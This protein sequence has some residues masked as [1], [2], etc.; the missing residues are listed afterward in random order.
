[1]S[2][3][4][5][6]LPGQSAP[7]LTGSLVGLASSLLSSGSGGSLEQERKKV[8]NMKDL[9]V[10]ET[11]RSLIGVEMKLQEGEK[12]EW[13]Y[14]MDVPLA[15]PP[16]HR[17]RAWTIEY[18][19]VLSVGV[20]LGKEERVEEVVSPVR[21]WSGVSCECTLAVKVSLRQGARL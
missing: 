13:E 1:M 12:R 16:S 2:F 18:K 20:R 11:A 8:W 6:T 14:E 10:L 17:G 4:T 3:G 21:M 7:S 19:M 15:M 9:P 5:G